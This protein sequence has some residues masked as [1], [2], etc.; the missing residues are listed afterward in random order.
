MR[1][2][3]RLRVVI[4]VVALAEGAEPNPE[5]VLAVIGR[6]ETSV[7]E[8]RHVADRVDRPGEIVNHEHRHIEAP[9][10]T[11]P[12]Q[13]EIQ[14]RGYAKMWQHIEIGAFPEAAVPNLPDIRRVTKRIVS[15]G[16]R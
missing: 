5:I 14:K 11:D 8:G 9:E 12:A 15:E 3:T 1:R 4:V 16:R 6:L 10:Q 13:G 7:A 2:A